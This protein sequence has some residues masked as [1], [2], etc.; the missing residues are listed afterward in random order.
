MTVEIKNNGIT[1]I[2][3]IYAADNKDLFC[4]YN[5]MNFGKEVWLGL[6]WYDKDNNLLEQPY[7]LTV[8][9]FVEVDEI[10]EDE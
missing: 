6:V 2:T 5:Q 10:V 3:V 1:D 4:T 8:D 7:M 9:D